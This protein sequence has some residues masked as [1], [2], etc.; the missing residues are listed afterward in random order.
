LDVNLTA[1]TITTIMKGLEIPMFVSEEV[2]NIESNVDEIL[3]IL[4][5][6][7]NY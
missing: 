6:G 1:K 2:K 7:I 4:F 3:S 5:Y